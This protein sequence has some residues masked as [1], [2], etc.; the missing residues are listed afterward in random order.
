MPPR[1]HATS[2]IG[3]APHDH[4][5]CIDT[6]L[7][8]AEV[9]CAASGLRLTPT[10]RRVLEILLEEHAALK[11]YDIL[12]RLDR[13]G[14]RAQPPVAYRA[15]GFLVEAG[16][17]H[18][19]EC[20]NAYVACSRPG[21][22]HAAAFLICAGCGAVAESAAAPADAI[23]PSAAR[24]GFRIEDAVLEARGLCPACQAGAAR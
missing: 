14:R 8:A 24:A 19:V 1:L 3:F 22:R 2:P 6:A 23:A 21:T 20:L 12:R 10:R 18:R 13:E 11:A 15:L 5:G 4:A 9:A 7:Q 17:A 16:L